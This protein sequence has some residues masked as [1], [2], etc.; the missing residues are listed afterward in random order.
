LLG[1]VKDLMDQNEEVLS[2]SPVRTVEELTKRTEGR[3]APDS[4]V[5]VQAFLE[6]G[7]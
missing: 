1:Q 2:S 7:G 4:E 5:D 6:G 3:A